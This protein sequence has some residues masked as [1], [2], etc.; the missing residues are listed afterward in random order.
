[1]IVTQP[2]FAVVEATS[3]ESSGVKCI[4]M[5]SGSR[6]EGQMDVRNPVFGSVDVEFIRKKP[7]SVVVERIRQVQTFE[8]RTIEPLASFNV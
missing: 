5:I 4:D 2:W 3:F 6:L 7:V 1:M 8:D